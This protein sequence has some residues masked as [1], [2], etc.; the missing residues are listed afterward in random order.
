MAC[1]KFHD[2]A[3]ANKKEQAFKMVRRGIN[4]I[5]A[6]VESS[7]ADVLRE[8]VDP[9][10]QE[11]DHMILNIAMDSLEHMEMSTDQIQGGDQPAVELHQELTRC[12]S[13]EVETNTANPDDQQPP[14]EDPEPQGTE[15]K[16]TVAATETETATVT[17]T[18]AAAAEPTHL[19]RLPAAAEP[20]AD[21][22]KLIGSIVSANPEYEIEFNQL[23]YGTDEA[24]PRY[25]GC[26]V[27]VYEGQSQNNR[28]L[29]GEQVQDA[30]Q[31]A[32][33]S[34][35]HVV[36]G[37]QL[38]EDGIVACVVQVPEGSEV[39][40]ATQLTSESKRTL[41]GWKEWHERNGTFDS[42]TL[43]RSAAKGKQAQAESFWRELRNAIGRQV[44]A[45][46]CFERTPELIRQFCTL[47]RWYHQCNHRRQ[48][49]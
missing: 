2:P 12:V 26:T 13:A 24:E 43:N 18:E 16:G 21:L 25:E 44:S 47:V 31:P 45:V 30:A 42:I 10:G 37:D 19:R 8:T 48:N 49:W 34:E 20:R 32:P 36:T 1:E 29:E 28:A 46:E 6:G 22:P 33:S 27:E 7:D 38:V 40:P 4:H 9:Q 15:G 17:K 5:E 41:T 11:D 23:W 3:Y 39:Q 35:L 14:G